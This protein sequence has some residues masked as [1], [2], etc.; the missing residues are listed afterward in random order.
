MKIVLN[1]KD[2]ETSAADVAALVGELGFPKVTV[3]VE[4]N[5]TALRREEWTNALRE[6]DR[7]ELLRIVAGG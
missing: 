5:G 3:L 6:G 7:V 2:H 4:L 1:G